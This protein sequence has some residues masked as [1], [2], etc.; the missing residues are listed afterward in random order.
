VEDVE[1]EEVQVGGGE[2]AEELAARVHHAVGW[3][4][5]DLEPPL[6]ALEHLPLVSFEE[7]AHRVAVPDDALR[8]VATPASQHPLGALLA[9]PCLGHWCLLSGRSIAPTDCTSSGVPAGG[10]EA[11]ESAV[12]EA[13]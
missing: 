3:L 2:A 7:V 13:A 10:L 9:L 12:E 4:R 5:A 8:V 1:S 11:A 6:A